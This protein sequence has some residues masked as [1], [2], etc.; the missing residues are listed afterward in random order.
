LE[1]RK[2]GIDD[3]IFIGRMEDPDPKEKNS[4]ASFRQDRPPATGEDNDLFILK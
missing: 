2:G 4:R 1:S 3:N